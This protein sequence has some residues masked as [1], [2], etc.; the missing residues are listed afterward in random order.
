MASAHYANDAAIG[1]FG[2]GGASYVEYGARQAAEARHYASAA[3]ALQ[4]SGPYD[5]GS[6]YN[7]SASTL[8]PARELRRPR[9]R[10]RSLTPPP[11][12]RQSR[13]THHHST[14]PSRSPSR[15]P[16]RAPSRA[17]SKRSRRTSPG[18]QDPIRKTQT[19]LKNTFSH[20]HSGLG[21]GVLGAIVGGLVAREA[22][23]G[24]GSSRGP[25]Q[26]YQEQGRSRVLSTVLGA[27]VGGFGANAIEKQRE[28]S[29]DKNADRSRDKNADQE[30]AGKSKWRRE[31]KGRHVEQDSEDGT[32]RRKSQRGSRA[33]YAR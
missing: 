10:H 8:Q 22:S 6:F 31:A 30:A 33:L 20:S 4:P 16:S 18:A 17:T 11:P 5:S 2:Y 15:S 19:L 14:P 21:V 9:T 32:G 23:D 13:R 24:R 26:S 1:R 3:G 28:K 7:A 25:R 27:A 29:R 12:R